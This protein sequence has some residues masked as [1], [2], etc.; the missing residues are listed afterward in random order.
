MFGSST[1]ATVFLVTGTPVICLA[2]ANLY[3]ALAGQIEF[4]IPPSQAGLY[5]LGYFIGG[6]RAM[7]G[8]VGK[9][10]QNV[11]TE[12]P[13][14]P[15]SQADDSLTQMV[16]P[17]RRFFMTF[18]SL[19]S[20]M[21]LLGLNLG[22]S[23]TV[24]AFPQLTARQPSAF[25]WVWYLTSAITVT[26]AVV[27]FGVMAIAAGVIGLRNPRLIPSNWAQISEIPESAWHVVR[28]AHRSRKLQ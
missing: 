14:P 23:I 25:E 3:V 18:M 19:G 17:K 20:A 15:A 28:D 8:G 12:R 7:S 2:A 27:G 13:T 11:P 5:G 6:L 26:V 16:I 4:P 21:V 22:Y 1:L 9:D 10:R 24:L